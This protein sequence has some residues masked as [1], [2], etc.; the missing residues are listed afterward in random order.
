MKILKLLPFT[1]LNAVDFGRDFSFT[2][3]LVFSLFTRI[4][5]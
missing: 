4:S 2:K 5:T 3:K 1:V